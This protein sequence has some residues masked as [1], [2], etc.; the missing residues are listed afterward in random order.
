[1]PAINLNDLN[2]AKLDVDHIA[3]IATSPLSAV[4]DR[5]GNTKRTVAGVI[6]A[7]HMALSVEVFASAPAGIA[8]TAPGKYFSVPATAEGEVLILYLNTAGVAVE[9]KRYPSA[10]ILEPFAKYTGAGPL[11][12]LAVDNNNNTIFGFN[13]TTGELFG[14]GLVAAS[15]VAATATKAV[16]DKLGALQQVIYKGEGSVI[17]LVLD[18]SNQVVFGFDTV[19]GKLIGPGL[20][21][22]S[23]VPAALDALPLKPVIRAINYLP[24]YGESTSVGAKGQPVLSTAQPYSNVTFNGGP[25]AAG[26]DYSAFK[27]L[28]EDALAAPDGGADRGETPCSGAANYCTT[29]RA[30]DGFAP[31]SMVILSSTAGHGGYRLD[32][33]KKG[34]AW[35]GT[36]LAHI[37][38]AKALNPDIGVPALGFLQ[39]INDAAA[40]VQTPYATWRA[41]MEQFQLDIEADIKAILPLNGDVYIL[42][43]QI[44]YAAATW[45]DIAKAQLSL[46]QLNPKFILTAP[47]HFLPHFSDGV[48]PNNVGSKWIGSYIG[49]DLKLIC[50]GKRPR[51]L[52]CLS[53]TRR[54][55]V[56]R[57]RFEV[58]HPPMVLDSVT[59]AA[60]TNSGFRVLDGA[61]TAPISSIAVDGSDVVI[62]LA[63]L[64][65]GAVTVRCGLDYLGAG[66]AITGA[67]STNLR[68]S[69]PGTV[70]IDGISR[71]LCNVAFHFDKPVTLLGE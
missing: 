7:G 59:L 31:N 39:G 6:D 57:L 66:L 29:L 46:A 48:H 25:R 69:E 12:P 15:S 33:L 19:A 35:Y 40:A 45:P 52:Q 65:A 67:A 24:F 30:L 3:A 38:A 16:T 32:Q 55:A 14:L 18:A 8:A 26:G 13:S 56:I 60:A 28:V 27:P 47:M 62:T 43:P 36:L 51:K 11:Y 49:R 10:K 20:G 71:P 37:T 42:M 17:P 21:G 63:G 4:T 22:A 53:A 70:L 2:N 50:D 9:K 54:G 64:P 41:M 1:M 68:D 5:L 58:P 23:A 34:S 61:V 44:S